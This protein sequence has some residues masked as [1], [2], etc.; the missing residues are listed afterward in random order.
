MDHQSPTAVR[1]AP[2]DA[3]EF[4]DMADRIGIF[5]V[6]YIWMD[7]NRELRETLS[8]WHNVYDVIS[9]FSW[10]SPTH[11]TWSFNV[12]CWDQEYSGKTYVIS[13]GDQPHKTY[14]HRIT[15][16]PNRLYLAIR[17]AI[18]IFSSGHEP[19]KAKKNRWYSR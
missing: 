1:T 3:D 7:V 11:R 8:D 14:E 18:I 9:V 6:E 2:L 19:V 15:V 10:D 12:E 4:I 13:W 16:S 5:H 17:E